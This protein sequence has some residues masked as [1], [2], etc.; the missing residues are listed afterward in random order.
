MKKL[1]IIA[2]FILS[3]SLLLGQLPPIPDFYYDYD[4]MV[5]SLLTWEERHPEIFKV[6]HIGYSQEDDLPIYAC[7]LSFNVDENEDKPAVLIVG[8]LHAEEILGTEIT[9][10]HIEDMLRRP[11]FP[12]Y[13]RW[14]QDLELWFI[15]NLNPEGWLVVTDDLDVTYRKNKRDN[16]GSGDFDFTPGMGY[17]KDGVDLNRNWDFNWVHGDSLWE[18]RPGTTEVYDYYRGPYPMSE[19][20]VQAMK[21]LTDRQH[22]IFSIVWHSSRSG[23]FSEKVY[24]SFNWDDLYRSPDLDVARTIGYGFASRIPKFRSSQYYESLDSAGRSGSAHDWLYKEYGQLNLLAEAGTSNLQ[25]QSKD[26]MLQ[27]V[28]DCTRGQS[29]LFDRALPSSDLDR[30]PLLTGHIRNAVTGEPIEAEVI[31]HEH[32]AGFFTP[33]V[34]DELYG[35]YWRPLLAGSYTLTFRKEGYETVTM[36]NVVVNNS[37]WTIVNADLEPLEPTNFTGTVLL[38]DDPVDAEIIIRNEGWKPVEVYNHVIEVS[39]GSFE[40]GMWK[41]T[42]DIIITAEGAYPYVGTIDLQPGTHEVQ[43]ILAEEEIIFHEDWE[44]GTDHWVVDG[45]WQVISPECLDGGKA[46]IES[47]DGGR[48]RYQPNSRAVLVTENPIDLSGY[49]GQDN[50]I[51]MVVFNQNLYTLWDQDY[52]HLDVST[53]REEWTNIYKYSGQFDYWH[54]IYAS[55]EP[56]MGEEIFLRFK[57]QADTPGNSG[58]LTDPGW[59]IENIK[60]VSGNSMVTNVEHGLVDTVKPVVSLGQNY[61]NPFNPETT[62]SFAVHHKDVQEAKISIYNIRGALVDT[63]TL[64]HH[65]LN[66]GSVGWNAR[67]HSSGVYLYQLILDGIAYDTKKAVLMK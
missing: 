47:Y 63:I 31:V 50:E 46:I 57:F 9:M 13:R 36:E 4:K 33:R 20:E 44:N 16:T 65:E 40:Y 28:S 53:D 45:F 26:D 24:H 59:M 15:P 52:V 7:K 32:H 60:V 58:R 2:L 35:R 5:D 42:K 25:P 54:P 43:I 18:I 41:G 22:F 14:L 6:E 19:S 48:N 23:L 21:S 10:R 62:I 39:N 17:D 30:S 56:F 66:R 3:A 37:N 27:V 61:P 51:P 11:N 55:L 12:R 64:D 8:S 49:D 29:W 1:T 34:S 67:K 38:G